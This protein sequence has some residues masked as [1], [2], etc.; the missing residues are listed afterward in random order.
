LFFSS[1]LASR[2][3]GKPKLE[4]PADSL[5]ARRL[6][7]LLSSPIIQ[8]RQSFLMKTNHHAFAAPGRFWASSFFWDIPY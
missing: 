5:G 1:P 3:R 8:P 7:I 2:R 6:V 4:Q